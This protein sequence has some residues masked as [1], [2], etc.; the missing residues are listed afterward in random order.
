MTLYRSDGII[1]ALKII[2][3]PGRQQIAQLVTQLFSGQPGIPREF[4]GTLSLTSSDPVAIA[5][6]RFRGVSFSTETLSQL[7]APTP[8]P[9]IVPGISG[10]GSS[11]L[12]P[13]FVL[14]GGW[15]TEII[16]VNTSTSPTAVRLDL[17]SANGG[18]L[19]ATLNGVTG[20]SFADF[21]ILAGGVLVIAPL[22]SRGNSQF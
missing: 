15:A 20:S 7:S 9:P 17:F 19:N 16:I 2:Q 10:G 18:P 21:N 5:A 12:L 4:V 14:G 8:V 3:V 11:F 13:N 1:A 6:L 22:D